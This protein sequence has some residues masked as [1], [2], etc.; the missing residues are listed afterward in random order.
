VF[1]ERS[2]ANA[3]DKGKKIKKAGALVEEELL[4]SF[5]DMCD[6]VCMQVDIEEAY[7]LAPIVSIDY[8]FKN[9]T[10]D[11][12]IPKLETPTECEDKEEVSKWKAGCSSKA[13]LH[14]KGHEDH[15]DDM[16]PPMSVYEDDDVEVDYEF[17]NNVAFMQIEL[18]LEEDDVEELQ[19]LSQ[20]R[21]TLQALNSPNM[22]VGDMGVTKHSTKHKQ[23]GINSKPSTSRTE[24]SMIKQL[25]QA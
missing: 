25:S 15:N 1:K 23:G 16:E 13:S 24:E 20:I 6:Y 7:V 17:Y 2:F 12:D 9:V 19:G 5:V 14:R 3:R 21:P 10:D 4:L 18:G 11:K 22:W 8:G